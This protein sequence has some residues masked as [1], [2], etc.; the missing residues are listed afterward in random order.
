MKHENAEK[1]PFALP[2]FSTSGSCR[3][4]KKQY[5]TIWRPIYYNISTKTQVSATQKMIRDPAVEKH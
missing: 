1:N 4:K 5:Y 3:H 2:E